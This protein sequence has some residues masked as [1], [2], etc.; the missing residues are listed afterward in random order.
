MVIP[1]PTDPATRVRAAGE[2]PTRRSHW[3]SAGP[4][5]L[6]R[7]EVVDAVERAV[8]ER[9]RRV[10]VP[11]SVLAAGAWALRRHQLEFGTGLGIAVSMDVSAHPGL[12]SLETVGV[13]P[14]SASAYIAAHADRSTAG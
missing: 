9:F 10:V 12:E 5:P 13:Q 11:R 8:G 4:E 3:T 7:H 6:T 1:T 2:W 14:R